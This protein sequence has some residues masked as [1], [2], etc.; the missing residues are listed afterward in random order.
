M[1]Q[2]GEDIVSGLKGTG[3]KGF[4]LR[5]GRARAGSHR[6]LTATHRRRRRAAQHPSQAEIKEE[7]HKSLR[8]EFEKAAADPASGAYRFLEILCL[9]ELIEAD[10]KTREMDVLEVFRAHSQ[11]RALAMKAAR[12]QSQNKVAEAQTELLRQ[13]IRRH[14]GENA[15]VGQKAARPSEAKTAEKPFNY[16][17]ALNQISAVIGL[18]GGEEFEHD[19]QQPRGNQVTS[20]Q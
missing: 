5:R 11:G 6:R 12:L 20:G 9:R 19:E 4:A 17:R 14:K 10:L 7:A 13:R 16:E 1:K 15:Q 3:N 2:N 18:R 8:A